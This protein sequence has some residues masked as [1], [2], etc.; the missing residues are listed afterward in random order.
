MANKIFLGI[1]VYIAGFIIVTF[2]ASIFSSDPDSSFSVGII[3]AILYLT[4]VLTIL[5]KGKEVTKTQK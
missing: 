3:A 2:T 5:L 1:L 4:S